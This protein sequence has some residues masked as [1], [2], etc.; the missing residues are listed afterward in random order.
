M[1]HAI[2]NEKVNAVALDHRVFLL[3]KA[4]N[5]AMI[6]CVNNLLFC[7][8]DFVIYK[9]KTVSGILLAAG[10]SNR[11]GLNINKVYLSLK[12]QQIPALYYPLA[13]F[14][15]NDYI[16]EIVIVVR[17]EDRAELQDMI[18]HEK[19]PRKPVWIAIGGENR[20]DS[21]Y[22]GLSISTGEI[23]M[24]HDGARPLLKQRFISDCV[25]AMDAFPGAIVGVKSIDRLCYTDKNGNM[26]QG[27]F[28]GNTYRVQTPQCFRAKILKE[29]HDKIA[30]K[31]NI[32]DDSTL[33]ERCGYPV[34]MLAGD[35][36][37]IKIT[38]PSDINIAEHYIM[39]D[40]EIYDLL[41]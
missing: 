13:A 11:M 32:T 3:T 31:S 30:D 39:H 8:G 16:D 18:I 21:V 22:N 17:T 33:L 1:Y 25:E 19:F 40:E 24:I 27:G 6:K 41:A 9:G 37:N 35:E 5:R 34:K 26:V 36:T 4:T 10:S 15:E 23:V 20:Y 2:V 12:A 38:V 28:E 29:C 7:K 14:E